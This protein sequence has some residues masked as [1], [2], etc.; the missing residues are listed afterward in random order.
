MKVLVF[1]LF[2]S[3][4]VYA[5]QAQNASSTA[6]ASN[7]VFY[8][9]MVYLTFPAQLTKVTGVVSILTNPELG[10]QPA[11]T[12]TQ[13]KNYSILAISEGGTVTINQSNKSSITLNAGI[14]VFKSQ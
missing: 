13:I 14:Y 6:T 7:L 9:E 2:V 1:L 12:G 8:Q 5:E 11:T 10:Y 3:N 4:L